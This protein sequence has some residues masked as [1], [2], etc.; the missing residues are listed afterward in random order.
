MRFLAELDTGGI[1]ADDMGLGKTIQVLAHL[2]DERQRGAL[3]GPSL[4][5][6][7]TSLVGNWCAETAR[8]A[9]GLSVLALQGS[10]AQRQRLIES[11]LASADLVVTTYPLLIRDLELL[12]EIPFGLLVLDEAQAIKNAASQT[13]HAVRGLQAQRALAV[14]GT[15]LE[16]HLGELWAQLDA[17]APG[18]LGSQ[19]WFGQHFRTPIEKE[20]DDVQRQR[21]AQRVAPLM[22]RRTKQQVLTELPEK[23]ES[24]R[25][26]TLSGTQRE[27]YDGLLHPLML[28]QTQALVELASG[29][30]SAG[31]AGHRRAGPGGVRHRHARCAAQA[32][33]GML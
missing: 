26:I 15:P 10:K 18:A 12:R 23:T 17:V 6:A 5:V 27:L 30:A 19:R 7:P 33:P 4:V 24:R 31:A 1:L 3:Q 9:P 14:T 21:L 11:D 22:L 13:A 2:L 28:G 32:A 16:N 20:G 25:E 8:F 29:P